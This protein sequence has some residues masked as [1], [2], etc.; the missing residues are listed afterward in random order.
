MC[1]SFDNPGS[2]HAWRKGAQGS[3]GYGMLDKSKYPFWSVGALSTSN[4]YYT[5]G[6][7]QGC[8]SAPAP[9]FATYLLCHCKPGDELST[10]LVF[11]DV[12]L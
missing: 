7:V 2:D 11:T 8:G 3:C 9:A 1:R 12:Y 10:L 4:M 5:A 6:P